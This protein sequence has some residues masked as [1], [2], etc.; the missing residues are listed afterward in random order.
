MNL[1][2][3]PAW[4]RRNSTWM[5]PTLLCCGAMTWLSFLYIGI[6]AKRTSWL[7][8]AAAYAVA[9][10]I[11]FALIS[12]APTAASGSTTTSDWRSTTGTFFLLAVWIGGSIHAL[13]VNREW[14]S[15]LA[16]PQE[17]AASSW[18]STRAPAVPIAPATLEEPWRSYMWQALGWQREIVTAVANNPPGPMRDRL[19]ELA[20][21][22]ETGMAECWQLA[23]GGQRLTHARAQINTA[24]VTQQLSRMRTLQPSPSLTQAAQSLQA[25]LDTAARIEREISSTYNGL[26]LMNA[27]LGEVEARV[28]ELSVRPNAWTE[29]AAVESV[30]ESVVNELVAIRQAIN[31]LDS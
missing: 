12:S 14:L 23:Q 21:H 13:I 24:A 22:V 31:E 27:R 30:V 2:Q 3:D 28:I 18:S 26:L 5:L 10:V 9:C 19:D 25:Q 29:V 6:N 4:R 16:S 15:Y 20:A 8:A 11:P 1:L 7:V 17:R